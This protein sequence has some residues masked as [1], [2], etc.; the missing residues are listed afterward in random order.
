MYRVAV[1]IF[2]YTRAAHNK[3]VKQNPHTENKKFI[4]FFL[5]DGLDME[6]KQ[7]TMHSTSTQYKLKAIHIARFIHRWCALNRNNI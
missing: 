1:F 2:K 6:E 5:L 3:T 4:A 7:S